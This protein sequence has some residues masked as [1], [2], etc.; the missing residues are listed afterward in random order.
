MSGLFAAHRPFGRTALAIGLC[1][2]AFIFAMEAK[3]AWYGP[4]S[5]P[6]GDVHAIKALPVDTPDIVSED[7]LAPDPVHP[8]LSF[9][10][11]APL[12][13]LG[14]ADTDTSLGRAIV[15]RYFKVS[16]AAYFSPNTFFRPP[17]VR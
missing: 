7:F 17:P 1:L 14:L 10:F 3:M 16:S 4:L 15:Q 9:A 8:H 2:L 13:A 12:I 5:G 11:L 6:D